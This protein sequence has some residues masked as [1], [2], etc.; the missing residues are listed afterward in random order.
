VK[1]RNRDFTEILSAET[2]SGERDVRADG[3]YLYPDGS[4]PGI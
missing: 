3:S 2:R 4:V 1:G